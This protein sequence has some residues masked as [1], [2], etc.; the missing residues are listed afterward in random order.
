MRRLRHAVLV[1][2]AVTALLGTT[3]GPAGAAPV[4]VQTELTS[5]RMSCDSGAREVWCWFSWTGGTAP[6]T[7]RW[8]YNGFPWP[9]SNDASALRKHCSGSFF[10]VS[11]VVTDV[12]GHSTSAGGTCACRAGDWR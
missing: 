12:H 8:T 3:A 4:S 9:E 7:I 5:P 1:G 10:T 2:A 11:A 6:F